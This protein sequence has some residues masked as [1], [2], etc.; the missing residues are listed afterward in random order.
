MVLQKTKSIFI[1]FP[2][3]IWSVIFQALIVSFFFFVISIG[4]E[5]FCQPFEIRINNK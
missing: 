3:E 5:K 2:I 1:S 4:R